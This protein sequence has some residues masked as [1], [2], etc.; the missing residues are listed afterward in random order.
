MRNEIAGSIL[1]PHMLNHDL[2]FM[3][4]GFEPNCEIITILL[5]EFYV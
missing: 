3:I 2:K 4:T 5:R 1:S